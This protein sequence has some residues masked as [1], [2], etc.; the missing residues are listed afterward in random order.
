MRAKGRHGTHSPFVY[1]FVEQVMRKNIPSLSYYPGS[2][3]LSSREKQLLYKTLLFL[4]PDRIYYLAPLAEGIKKIITS[5]NENLVPEHISSLKDS[6]TATAILI[7]DKQIGEILPEQWHTILPKHTLFVRPH[8]NPVAETLWNN[9]WKDDD[10]DMSLDYWHF[11]LLVC[12]TAF[13]AKQH[14]YIR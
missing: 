13:K 7:V 6:Q 2:E 5:C 9:M 3:D 1:A 10:I 12:D 14:F 4:K 11:G 8:E